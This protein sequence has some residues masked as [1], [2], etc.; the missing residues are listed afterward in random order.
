MKEK[1]I[2]I[3]YKGNINGKQQRRKLIFLK[4]HPRIHYCEY[5]AISMCDN[6]IVHNIYHFYFGPWLHTIRSADRHRHR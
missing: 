3:S 1:K 6:I 2:L 5:V 4:F